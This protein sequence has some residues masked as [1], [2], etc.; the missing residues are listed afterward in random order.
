MN[1]YIKNAHVLLPLPSV[2]NVEYRRVV[3]NPS[4]AVG[5]DGKVL[6]QKS[7]RE[8]RP[9]AVVPRD[10]YLF[11]NI[12][13]KGRSRTRGIHRLMLEAFVGVPP[14]PGMECRHLDGVRSNNVLINLAWGTQQDNADDRLR[15]G[16]VPRGEAS[17]TAKINEVQV[18][19][20]MGRLAAGDS[21]RQIAEAF[22]VSLSEVYGINK[23][24]LWGHLPSPTGSRPIS[25]DGRKV[26]GPEE[27]DRR[28]KV[29]A[30]A[31]AVRMARL[32]DVRAVA[33]AIPDV[34]R[35]KPQKAAERRA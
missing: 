29:A 18:L 23:G 16:T 4:Y 17:P 22:G 6:S 7:G 9:V 15:H 32:A 26:F 11:V 35:P 14:E 19:A 21:K 24:K 13:E 2:P 8:W 31:R 5:T 28:Q 20:I 10:G 1:G 25:P 27:L 12:W 33:E 30:H 34:G 3:G